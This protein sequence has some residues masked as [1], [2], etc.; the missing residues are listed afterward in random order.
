[1]DVYPNLGFNNPELGLGNWAGSLCELVNVYLWILLKRVLVNIVDTL[2]S[3]VLRV[4][5]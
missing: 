4:D 2:C 1:M 5:T 3:F